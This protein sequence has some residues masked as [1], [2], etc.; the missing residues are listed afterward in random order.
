MVQKALLDVVQAILVQ[1]DSLR[2]MSQGRGSYIMDFDR[3]Q[4]A[5]KD[6]EA[7]VVAQAKAKKE[8]EQ[9]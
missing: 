8:A 4:Q 2:A 3:Y 5:P 6:V 7:K 9:K 1:A